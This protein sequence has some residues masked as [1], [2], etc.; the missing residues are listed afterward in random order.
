MI[1]QP[2]SLSTSPSYPYASAV[3]N[4]NLGALQNNYQVLQKHVGSQC[5]IAPVVKTNAYGL[6]AKKAAEALVSLG[7]QHF[8]VATFEEAVQL[9]QS[10]PKA[11]IYPLNGLWPDV[12]PE[13]AKHN[14]IPVLSSL[15]QIRHWQALAQKQSR[16][17]PFWLQVDTGLHRLGISLKEAEL[18]S[19]SPHLLEGLDLKAIMSHLACGYDLESAYNEKQRLQFEQIAAFFP[20]TLKSFANSG[21]LLGDRKYFYDIA[22][23]G[24]FLY[25]S[26]M[27]IKAPLLQNLKPIVT[28]SARILQVH[29]VMKGESIGYDQT[30]V[31]PQN[32]RIA[33]LSIG[34]GDGYFQRLSNKAYGMTGP[35]KA[36]VVGR[37]S[38]DLTTVDVSDI[39]ANHLEQNDW[40]E[41]INHHIT[42]DQ[43]A[44]WSQTNA[45]EV[46]THLGK[47]LHVSY[48]DCT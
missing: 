16:T 18:L 14:I 45:W 36:P 5:Q 10:T 41:L 27:N 12:M 13:A 34:Y 42:V 38:M 15:D 37:I 39:P 17:L 24:R 11:H 20:N 40:V 35:F 31:A 25:G 4:I 30:F 22:R 26:T 32:M 8:F 48:S 46:L 7:A 47:R 29:D 21:A 23:P 2:Q 43:L 1:L 44:T 33:T 19:Q 6:G 9:R 28:L 3:M